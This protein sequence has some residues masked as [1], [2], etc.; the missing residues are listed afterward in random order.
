M[1]RSPSKD[2]QLNP[3][4]WHVPRWVA[5][6]ASATGAVL[7]VA[8]NLYSNEFRTGISSAGHL[9]GGELLSVLLAALVAS[10]ITAVT[11]RW[12]VRQRQERTQIAPGCIKI[13]ADVISIVKNEQ[14]LVVGRELH[15][16]EVKRESPELVIFLH[17]LG[18]DAQDFRPYMAESRYHCI[19]LTLYRFNAGEQE[20]THYRP[21]SLSTHIQLLA[22][23]LTRIAARHPHKRMTLVGFSFGADIIFLLAAEVAAVVRKL[24]ISQTLLLDP[25]VNSSTTT[26][27]S[28]IAVIDPSRPIDELTKILESADDVA[29]FRNL[30]HYLY[31]ITAKN[32]AQVQRHAQDMIALWPGHSYDTF[33]DRLGQLN[34]LVGGVHVVLSF[35]YEKN[36]NGIARGAVTRGL[37]PGN[38]ACSRV[39]HFDLI[40][41]KFLKEQLEG[42][43]PGPRVASTD[44]ARSG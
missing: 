24:N 35:D 11:Y 37:D 4:G 44:P 15:Y 38:L 17:G 6:L 1:P 39:D 22:Y 12:L 43:L 3:F 8:T 14:D 5:F 10:A 30:C 16:L 25:N 40:G 36:F 29:E 13:G 9:F 21:I 27:S 7:G 34:A 41:A 20:D 2:D 42:V 19:A 18:L 26:I 32:F 33:L 28:R 23:A 31:K